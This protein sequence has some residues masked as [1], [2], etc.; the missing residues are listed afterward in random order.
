MTILH[1]YMKLSNHIVLLY[2]NKIINQNDLRSID[3]ISLKKIKII[4][5]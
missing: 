2:N 3:V 4:L 5:Y 1:I